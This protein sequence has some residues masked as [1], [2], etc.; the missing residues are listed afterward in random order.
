MRAERG[1]LMVEYDPYSEA[2]MTDP[3]PVY[4]QLRDEDPAHYIEK[5]DAWALS[6]FEDV[7][8]ACMQAKSISTASGTTGAQLLTRVQPVTP[9]I[10]AMDP[11][12]HTHLRTAFRPFF[13]PGRMREVEPQIR[14]I[15]REALDAMLAR[16]EGDLVGDFG[17]RI[18]TRAAAL[19]AGFPREDCDMLYDLVQRFMG[20]EE[21][22]V[23]MTEDGLAAM[24][25]MGA[26]FYELTARRRAAGT[27]G[28]HP[29]DILM[30]FERDGRKLAEDE[31]ASHM[32]MLVVGGTDTF[33]KVFANLAT[34]L[35]QNPEQRAQIVA[36]PSLGPNAFVEG[37]RIDMPTQFLGRMI[38]RDME[39]HG[40]TLRVGQ[41]LI[42]LY[43]SANR[44]ERE[45][46]DPETFDIHRKLSRVLS[47]GHGTHSCLG[48]HSA[49]LEGKL[50]LEELLA[51]APEY[52]LDLANAERHKTE[53]V[54][55]F[56][57]LPV[58]F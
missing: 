29:H 10:A 49:K 27:H 28:A 6:R 54:Q 37:V 30:E 57:S 5:Y 45:F 31:I 35:Y 4:R 14:A 51:S 24:N 47:F 25:E 36:D 58:K 13:A 23:G 17:M 53:F 15:V 16:G 22:V 12:E 39:F 50:A 38:V 11:P 44:D 26:Y 43:P 56:A 2:I 55:G 21:G 46:D 42:F 32:I 52:T 33:P 1:S 40:K 34:R 41:P 18:A 7:W 8:S 20:R 9:M 48:I 3:Y 19:L